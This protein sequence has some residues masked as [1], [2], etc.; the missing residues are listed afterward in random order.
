MRAPSSLPRRQ[1]VAAD[2]ES[3][4]RRLLLRYATGI[5][6]RDWPLF[7]TCFSQDCEADYGSFG[8]WRGPREITEYMEAAH[9]HMGSTLH[10]ITNI[11][12]ENCND[13]IRA[14]SYVDAILTEATQGGITHRAAGYY[15]DALVR[16]SDGWKIAR[17]RFTMVK[18][19]L[20]G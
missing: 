3:A 18:A 4:I 2:D 19:G 15:D 8:S 12:V 7:R 16:T 5:D 20:D 6:T 10:R 17:R 9:R 11:V 14:R 13:E 1:P